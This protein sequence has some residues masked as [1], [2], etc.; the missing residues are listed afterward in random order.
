ME[1][2]TLED[3]LT[4]IYR[5]QQKNEQVC[6]VE[7]ARYLNIRK[8]SFSEMLSKLKSS[9]LVSHEK[10]GKIKLTKKGEK[11]AKEVIFKHRVIEL[12][13]SKRLGRSKSAVHKEAHELE[14]AFSN[15]SVYAI[16]N[17][18]GKPE[19]GIHG[20]EIPKI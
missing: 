9:S 19:V 3:Y 4:A 5:L 13:L 10:Y 20:E 16:Y 1:K 11:S 12:F 6:S 18:L 2:Q 15:Q 7:V 8:S 17:L 14:H